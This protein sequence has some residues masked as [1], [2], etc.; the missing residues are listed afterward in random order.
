MNGP[1]LS[2]RRLPVALGLLVGAV[3]VGVGWFGS[4]REELLGD[5][6]PWIVVA[7]LGSVVAVGVASLEVMRLRR[8]VSDRSVAVRR[9]IDRLAVP[10][11]ARTGAGA[12]TD[13]VAI[14]VA[15]ARQFHDPG[16]DLV[17]HRASLVHASRA[18]HE[19]AGRIPCRVC[20]DA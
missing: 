20:L 8:E 4:R 17:A 1:G 16:C 3:L 14:A 9:R 19:A 12:G 10:A 18:G 15:G 7:V 2:A 13:V 5:Q 6:A 11:S